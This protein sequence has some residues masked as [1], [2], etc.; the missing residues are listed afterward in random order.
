MCRIKLAVVELGFMAI[1]VQVRGVRSS[2]CLSD[3]FYGH[4]ITKPAAQW[5]QGDHE[6]EQKH[7]HGLNDTVWYRKFPPLH[8]P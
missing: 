2:A 1:A 3:L 5:Q 4:D 8:P 6:G 7:A